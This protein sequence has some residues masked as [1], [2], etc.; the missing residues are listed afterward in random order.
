LQCGKKLD[1][2]ELTRPNQP[3]AIHASEAL[4]EDVSLYL[5]L[6]PLLPKEV[7]K[8]LT[9]IAFLMIGFFGA[10]SVQAGQVYSVTHQATGF[11]TT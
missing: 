11:G 6:M 9:N 1:K 7:D 3:R 4:S 8:R 5:T 2:F 10:Y